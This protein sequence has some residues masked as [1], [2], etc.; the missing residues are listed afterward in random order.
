MN[1]TNHT[2]IDDMLT[3]LSG[4]NKTDLETLANCVFNI[5]HGDKDDSVYSLCEGR[6][7]SVCK[8]CGSIHIVKRGKN[9]KGHQKYWCKDCGSIFTVASDTVFSFTHKEAATWRNFIHFYLVP[10]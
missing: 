7:H 8:K 10:Q 5:L 4:M 6:D 1:I 3:A 2:R 9:P